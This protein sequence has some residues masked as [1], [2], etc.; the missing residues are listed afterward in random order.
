[1]KSAPRRVSVALLC[2]AFALCLYRAATQSFT[3]DEAFTFLRYV[4]TP[5]RDVFGDFSANNHVLFSL[6]SRVFRYKFGRSE[7]VL[8]IP[9]LIGCILYELASF[10]I[11]RD[12]IG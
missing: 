7:I 8:R 2:A 4:D 12:A 9:T 11:C 1:M 6:I 5:W 3:I 10:R